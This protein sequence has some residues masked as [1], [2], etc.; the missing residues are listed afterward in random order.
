MRP[1]RRTTFETGS[2]ECD[3]YFEKA[4]SCKRMPEEAREAV[5]KAADDMTANIAEGTPEARAA[6]A[7]SCRQAFDVVKC[8]W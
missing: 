6:F 4:A 2:A 5:R 1:P 3:R 7:E 8:P